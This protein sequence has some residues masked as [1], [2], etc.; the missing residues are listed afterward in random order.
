MLLQN[1]L[2]LKQ[3]QQQMKTT[4]KILGRAALNYA[5]AF[6]MMGAVIALIVIVPGFY[7]RLFGQ[8]LTIASY[9]M[10]ALV[11]IYE[12]QRTTPCLTKATLRIFIGDMTQLRAWFSD[13]KGV[14]L[15]LSSLGGIFACIGSV[16]QVYAN[17]VAAKP[18]FIHIANP[19]ICIVV[20]WAITNKVRY[21]NDTNA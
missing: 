16:S 2:P 1:G 4:A 14:A 3:E 19:L 20:Y 21:G 13:R 15:L 12:L 18:I 17:Q 11:S 9:M 7:Q 6:A 8:F 10:V 5:V